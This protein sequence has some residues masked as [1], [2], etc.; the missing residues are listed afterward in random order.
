MSGGTS[1]RV[2]AAS[3]LS[4][5]VINSAPKRA[6]ST[7]SARRWTKASNSPSASLGRGARNAGATPT[8]VGARFGDVGDVEDVGDVVVEGVGPVGWCSRI[9]PLVVALCGSAVCAELG[10]AKIRP[11]MNA[12]DAANTR[13]MDGRLRCRAALLLLS[14][15][16]SLMGMVGTARAAFARRARGCVATVRTPP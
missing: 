10:S 14:G 2:S 1:G 8:G 11:V 3:S 6:I 16:W 4:V 15:V 12:N 7:G 9:G 13:Y 5:G